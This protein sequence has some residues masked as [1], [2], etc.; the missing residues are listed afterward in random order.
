MTTS[1]KNLSL[2]KWF[3]EHALRTDLIVNIDPVFMLDT[4]QGIA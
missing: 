2:Y 3:T 4:E 1:E